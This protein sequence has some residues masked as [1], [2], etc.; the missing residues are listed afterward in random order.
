MGVSV[1]LQQI[2]GR[3]LQATVWQKENYDVAHSGHRSSPFRRTSH[4]RAWDDPFNP[5]A[6]P[7]GTKFLILHFQNLNFKPGDKLEVNLGYDTDT[8]TAVDGPAF[9]TRPVNV[10][11]LP[12]GV[13]ITYVAAGPLTG[14][15]SSISMAEA[16]A[17]PANR[18]ITAFRIAIRSIN[19][20]PIRSRSMMTGG[21]ARLHRTGRMRVAPIL[22]RT[23]VPKWR[24]A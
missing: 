8:F 21:S 4:H 3:R 10:Y 22:P 11:A 15:V 1:E 6:A 17:T 5:S 24:V 18:V 19:L 20:P 2:A 7:G 13:P 12:L 14:S 23:F 9:W 16:S